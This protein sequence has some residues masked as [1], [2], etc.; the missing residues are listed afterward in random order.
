MV[1]SQQHGRYDRPT[2]EKSRTALIAHLV[3]VPRWL[4]LFSNFF[5]TAYLFFLEVDILQAV[6]HSAER[7]QTVY[8]TILSDVSILR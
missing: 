7:K 3:I 8:Q 4:L 2:K 5:W 1:S 6:S